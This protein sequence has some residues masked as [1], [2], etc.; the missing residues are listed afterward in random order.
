[1]T[2]VHLP[3]RHDISPISHVAL[4]SPTG[5]YNCQH[6]A[7]AQLPASR[8]ATGGPA[9][10]IRHSTACGQDPQTGAVSNANAGRGGH[11]DQPRKRR[12]PSLPRLPDPAG[13]GMRRQPVHRPVRAAHRIPQESTD[14]HQVAFSRCMRSNGVT[15]YPDPDSSGVIP[16]ESSQ[17]L[18][19]TI[20]KFQSAQN[21]L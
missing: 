1:M 7:N 8:M 6:E 16:K 12:P 5:A 13:G 18:G 15:N 11:G 21:V 17:Q 19:V 10:L 14:A 9:G 2:H 20:S 4:M 3:S